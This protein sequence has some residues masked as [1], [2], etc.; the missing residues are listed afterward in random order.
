MNAIKLGLASFLFVVAATAAG[1]LPD[2]SSRKPI[3]SQLPTYPELALKGHIIGTV[4]LWFEVNAA[5]EVTSVHTL[6]GVFV[7]SEAA[8]NIVKSWKFPAGRIP[9]N[10]RQETEFVYALKVRTTSGEPELT[11]SLADFRKVEITSEI[12]ASIVY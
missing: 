1:P 3:S 12:Y 4:K 7:L 9:P 2:G 5:G 6:S 11:V 8:V 10:V